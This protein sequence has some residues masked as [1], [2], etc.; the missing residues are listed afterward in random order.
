MR[1]ITTGSLSSSD[2]L[3]TISEHSKKVI[4]I[5]SIVYDA[6]HR[7]I[8]AV[9]NAVLEEENLTNIHVIIQDK[10]AL[11]YTIKARLKSAIT[12][13]KEANHES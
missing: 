11:D 6:F 9:I 4:E 12:R 10:G 3:I 13:L 1:S 8:E 7:Q 2:C 5:D